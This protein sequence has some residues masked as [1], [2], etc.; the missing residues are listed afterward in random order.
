MSHNNV[1]I[2]GNHKLTREPIYVASDNQLLTTLQINSYESPNAVG[3]NG[4]YNEERPYQEGELQE[5]DLQEALRSPYI[6]DHTRNLINASDDIYLTHSARAAV[7]SEMNMARFIPVNMVEFRPGTQAYES[8]NFKPIKRE[9]ALIHI[10][11][12]KGEAGQLC[13]CKDVTSYRIKKLVS[14]AYST[15]DDKITIDLD[16]LRAFIIDLSTSLS[17]AQDKVANAMTTLVRERTQGT[18]LRYQE[19]AR[20]DLDV[21][22]L[23]RSIKQDTMDDLRKYIAVLDELDDNTSVVDLCYVILEISRIQSTLHMRCVDYALKNMI[24]AMGTA[25]VG[26]IH[27]V[28][29]CLSSHYKENTQIVSISG[30][31][32][33]AGS[34]NVDGFINGIRDICVSESTPQEAIDVLDASADLLAKFVE[35]CQFLEY[36]LLTLAGYQYIIKT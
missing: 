2:L 17:E 30:A 19:R 12:P 4:W 27:Q 21:L 3:I 16:K 26:V 6:S 15:G 18:Y 31:S 5:L 28:S 34:A 33:I 24:R 10:H 1:Y 20:F 8:I 7:V 32:L 36:D 29:T 35:I 14:R 25:L 9:G 13:L 11:F 22:N 23:C